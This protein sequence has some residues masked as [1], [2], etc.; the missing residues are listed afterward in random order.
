[1]LQCNLILQC[2][3]QPVRMQGS[4]TYGSMSESN[5]DKPAPHEGNSS[6]VVIF[7]HCSYPAK[8]LVVCRCSFICN[9]DTSDLNI[10]HWSNY[11]VVNAPDARP[12]H[13]KGRNSILP[14][15]KKNA[16]KSKSKVDSLSPGW[17]DWIAA[18]V[19]G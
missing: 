19:R 15:G 7:R 9:C 10:S 14:S 1:M 6:P 4:D 2:D 5:D 18:S 13:L 3:Q 8:R 16:R 17:G 12:V 11:P